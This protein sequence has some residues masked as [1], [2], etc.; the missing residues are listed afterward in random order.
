MVEKVVLPSFRTDA[1]TSFD[2]RQLVSAL[3]FRFSAIENELNSAVEGDFA[4]LVHTHVEADVTDL[5]PYLI[6]ITAESI[7][8][9]SDVSGS[10]LNGEVLIWDGS[11]FVPGAIGSVFDL[12][13]LGDVNVPSPADGAFLF[14]NDAV[15]Q[16]ESS[17]IDLS[18]FLDRTATEIITGDYTFTTGITVRDV[19]NSDFLTLRY[20]DVGSDDFEFQV[21]TAYNGNS[22]TLR[23][24]EWETIVWDGAATELVISWLNS[25]TDYVSIGTTAAG[26]GLARVLVTGVGDIDTFTYSGFSLIEA[27][28]TNYRLSS[29][30]LGQKSAADAEILLNGQLWV[31]DDSPN[32][33]MFTD[34]AGVDFEVIS[35]GSPKRTVG[36]T[37]DGGGSPP[38]AGSIGYV[39]SQFSGTI[40]QWH[41]VADVSGSAVID[42]WKAAGTIPTDA[43]R[44]AGTEKPTLSSQQLAN[45]IALTTWSTLAVTAGDVIGF[46]LESATTCT[47]VTCQVRVA[48]TL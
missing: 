6:D 7:F 39:I 35:S 43:N 18:N 11:A 27:I 33:L 26:G 5:Q 30:Y 28:S 44:I 23:F 41:M 14:W 1:F 38:T 31:R 45:D 34:N 24:M 32:I 25:A 20:I 47:R 29:V 9:L 10:P 15:S 13:D 36:M 8:D 2:M 17:E 16:W 37:F 22:S 21:E 4:P 3:E 46:E 42:V 48:E 19:T 12:N 40:D